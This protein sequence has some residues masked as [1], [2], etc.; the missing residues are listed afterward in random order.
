MLLSDALGNPDN[1]AA[2]LLLQLQVGV[3]HSEVELL[4]KC[5]HIELDLN[6]KSM[7]SYTTT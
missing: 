6:E 5:V 7:I 4:H 1:I 3:K 2:F